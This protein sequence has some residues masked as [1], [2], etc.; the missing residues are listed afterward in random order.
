MAGMGV[1]LI[2]GMR[3][4]GCNIFG[5]NSQLRAMAEVYAADDGEKDFVTDFVNAWTRVV[6]ADRFDLHR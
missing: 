4:I 1:A 2:G 3:A 6:E 5:T